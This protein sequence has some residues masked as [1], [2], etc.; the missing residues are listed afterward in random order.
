MSSIPL[1][2]P[3]SMG[4]R[5]LLRRFFAY[6]RPHRRLFWIDFSCAIVSGVLELAFP[7]A[8]GLFIDELLP[9]DD[10]G[11]ITAAAAGLLAVYLSTPA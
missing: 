10:W 6:Y 7:M 9:G 3:H 2:A 11:L 8:V 1:S 4:T 5:A